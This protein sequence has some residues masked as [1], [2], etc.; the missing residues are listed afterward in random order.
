MNINFLELYQPSSLIGKEVQL[1]EVLASRDKRQVLQQ[2]CLFKHSCCLL[3]I[4]LISPGG[5]KKNKLL[6][7]IFN[8]ALQVIQSFIDKNNIEI[9]EKIILNEDAGLYSL[10]ALEINPLTLKKHMIEI[11]ESLPIARLW[12][13]DVLDENGKIIS[14]TEVG[15][16]L[17]RK[18]LICDNNAKV[19]A[20]ERKHSMNEIYRKMQ[21]LAGEDCFALNFAELAEESLLKELNLTPKPGLVDQHNSGSHKD[22]NYDTF[23]KSTES[24]KP[25]FYEFIVNAMN[26]KYKNSEEVFFSARKIGINAEKAMFIATEGINTHKGSIF[27]FGLVLSAIGYL[28]KHNIKID[29]YRISQF[30]SEATTSLISELNDSTIK[31][32]T[33]GIRL[34]REHQLQGARGEAT[35]GYETIIKNSLPTYIKYSNLSEDHRLAITLLK[36]ISINDDTNVVNR[37]GIKELDWIKNYAL[38]IL[39]NSSIYENNIS[40]IEELN[41]FDKLCI[42]K[43]ISPGG[44]ADLLALTYFFSKL[45]DIN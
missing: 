45:K 37:G 27:S 5:V 15:N 26:L 42:D 13:L 43:N 2:E 29:E 31:E 23:I 10:F 38:N 30:I 16:N 33:A 17:P 36:L 22:M 11:E 20:R 24:L 32:E 4:S 25:Y 28:Y 18:C 9:N 7:Y 40:I 41:H 6:E 35:S 1:L 8:R 19:C 21:S 44:S 39:S 34:F 12:D 3:S 14:R